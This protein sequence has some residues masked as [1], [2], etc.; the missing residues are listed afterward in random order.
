VLAIVLLMPRE[1]TLIHLM[2]FPYSLI[3]LQL[4]TS[5]LEQIL[6]IRNVII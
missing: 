6:K 1:I 5:A 2:P 4:F 3:V